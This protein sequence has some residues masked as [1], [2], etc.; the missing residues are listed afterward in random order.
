VTFSRESFVFLD[1]SQ[2]VKMK[3]KA[4]RAGVWYK[5]LKRIDRVLVDLTIDVAQR[6]RSISLAERLSLV[7]RK[8]EHVLESKVAWLARE[9]GFPLALKLGAMAQAWGNRDAW[10]W[11]SD[12]S[13]VKYLAVMR[14]N[15]SYLG[16]SR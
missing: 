6:I 4:V 11:A 16:H 13:F 12:L 5:A 1:K 8:L 14:F 2:L 15:G 3:L 9:V 10:A 7:L